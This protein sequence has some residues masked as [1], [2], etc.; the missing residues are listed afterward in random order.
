MIYHNDIS[1]QLKLDYSDESQL[2]KKMNVFILKR[3]WV[4]I[5]TESVIVRE[6]NILSKT[7]RILELSCFK[8]IGESTASVIDQI[9]WV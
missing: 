2:A 1:D 8:M 7:T 5:T 9:R 3:D 4:S 6:V